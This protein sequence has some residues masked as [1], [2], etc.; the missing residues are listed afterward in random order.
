MFNTDM[1]GY[2]QP[3]TPITMSFM[4]RYA[5]L[6]LTEITMEAARTYVPGLASEYTQV[7]C[8]DQQSFYEN[9]FPSA[10]IFETPTNSVVYPHY[11]RSTDELQYINMEQVEKHSTATMASAALWAELV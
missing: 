2:Q 1:V 5:D 9:G 3:G 7:C 11:H 10:G 6:D 8:S 4:N